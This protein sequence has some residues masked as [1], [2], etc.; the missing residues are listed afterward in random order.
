MSANDPNAALVDLTPWF[1]TETVGTHTMEL[2]VRDTHGKR[3]MTHQEKV[4]IQPKGS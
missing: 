3:T 2:T 4:V 1:M